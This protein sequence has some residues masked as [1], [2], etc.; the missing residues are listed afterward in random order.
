MDVRKRFWASALAATQCIMQGFDD[1]FVAQSSQMV[2][3]AIF[4]G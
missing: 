4:L 3:G 1:E 2:F